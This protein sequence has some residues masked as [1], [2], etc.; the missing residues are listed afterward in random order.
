MRRRWSVRQFVDCCRKVAELLDCPAFTTDV[1]V[2]FPGE[3]DADFERTCQCARDVG[4]SKIHVFPFSPRRGTP[5]AEMEG[6]IPARVKSER[7][8]RLSGLEAELRRNYFQNLIGRRLRVL[9][10]NAHKS[11]VD[12]WLGTSCRYAPVELGGARHLIGQ[13]V[14]VVATE[15]R[16]EMLA[17]EVLK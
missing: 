15:V 2:G 1:I 9:V 10:E 8:Q 4:F 5:A 16:G 17:G 12:R 11:A 13:L 7:C 14:D 3:T 6:Q